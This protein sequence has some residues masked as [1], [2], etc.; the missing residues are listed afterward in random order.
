MKTSKKKWIVIGIVLTVVI[1]TLVGVVL[2][3]DYSDSH[4]VVRLGKYRGL[5]VDAKGKEAEDAVTE[6]IVA[7][8]WF[9]SACDDQIELDYARSIKGF[10]MEAEYLKKDFETFTKDNYNMTEKEF[11][12]MVKE[13]TRDTIRQTAVLHAIAEKEN[14]TLSDAEFAKAMPYLMEAYGYTDEEEFATDVDLNELRDELLQEKVMAF[15]VTQNEIVGA[16]T[17][18]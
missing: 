12:A 5:N 17:R 15:L 6:A 4:M 13:A 11:R 14:I 1:L 18:D 3:L 9:G 16:K 7:N 8:T 10:E 2:Y